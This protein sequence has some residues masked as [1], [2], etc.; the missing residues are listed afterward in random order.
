MDDAILLNSIYKG[1]Y[2]AEE[3]LLPHGDPSIEDAT[4]AAKTAE[5]FLRATRAA[6]P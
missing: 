4:R 6:L 1:R 5:A 3:G 2:P